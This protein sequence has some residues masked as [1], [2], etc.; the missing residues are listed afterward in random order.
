[1]KIIS[2]WGQH[3]FE[4]QDDEGMYVRVFRQPDGLVQVNNGMQLID[5]A[6][7]DVRDGTDLAANLPGGVAGEVAR[8]WETGTPGR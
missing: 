2:D 3:G 8:R 1:M 5:P 6:T 7:G 4:G